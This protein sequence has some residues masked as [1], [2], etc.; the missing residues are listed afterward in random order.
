M[1][2]LLASLI[3]F[4]RLPWWRL[5]SV[6]KEAF[7]HVVDYWPFVGWL[8]GGLMAGVYYLS[9]LFGFE[10][11][12]A[13]LLALASRLL[14]TGAARGWL[15]RFLRRLWR[16]YGSRAYLIYN[17]G[18]SHRYIRRLG[19]HLLLRTV[20]VMYCFAGRNL[21]LRLVVIPSLR[22]HGEVCGLYDYGTVALCPNGG[23]C[24]ERRCLCRTFL[25]GLVA[26]WLALC[27]R[28]GSATRPVRMDR[29]WTCRASAPRSFHGG[30]VAHAVDA[31]PLRW[32]Y[33]RLLRCAFPALRAIPLSHPSPLSLL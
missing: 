11:F 6:P 24:Q 15:G 29:S 3:F 21:D 9:V 14:L 1:N 8:T 18:L 19:T 5:K 2:R 25:A 32:L 4:T 20:V 7:E 17:E 31:S 13:A 27:R 23:R 33:R 28:L 16:R 12:V 10:P 26:A 22:C 30:I